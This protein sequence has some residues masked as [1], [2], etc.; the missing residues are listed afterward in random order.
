MIG[1]MRRTPEG[2][3]AQ[4]A[5]KSSRLARVLQRLDARKRSANSSAGDW[6]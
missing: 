3:P 5:R 4:P 2:E 1:A 6:A